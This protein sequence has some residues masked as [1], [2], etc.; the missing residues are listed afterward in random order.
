MAKQV[1]LAAQARTQIGRSAV[2]KL[3]QQ[4]LVPATIYGGTDKPMS[5]QIAGRD[6]ETVLS[7]A[8][9]ESILVELDI[10][11]QGKKSNR[12]ALIQEVQHH[13]VRRQIL[14]V[15]FHS[16]KMDENI[17]AQIPVEP[18]GTPNGVKNFG[19]LL[20]QSVRSIEV[21][22]LPKDLPEIITVDVAALNVGDSIHIKDIQLPAGV[23]AT[24][25]P[26]LTVFIVAEPTVAEEPV[27]TE[28]AAAPEVIKEKKEEPAAEGKK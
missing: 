2:N 10:T 11:D 6:I 9:G 16:V 1:K 26:D 13:P 7:H 25:D 15:D 14:H 21:E 27:A 8:V 3:K 22:C 24:D 19:G 5:L 20:E 23:T 4:G 12:L 17:T 18:F 28:A